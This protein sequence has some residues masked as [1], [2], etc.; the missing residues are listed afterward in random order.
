MLPM[1]NGCLGLPV[2]QLPETLR[3]R[4]PA[5]YCPHLPLVGAEPQDVAVVDL[6]GAVRRGVPATTYGSEGGLENGHPLGAAHGYICP[7][8]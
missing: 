2:D 4:A 8:G 5:A 1:A 6:A 7:K 3:A